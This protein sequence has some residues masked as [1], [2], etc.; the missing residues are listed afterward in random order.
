MP[1]GAHLPSHKATKSA[2]PP[3]T[4]NPTKAAKGKRPATGNKP[5]GSMTVTVEMMKSGSVSVNVSAPDLNAEA[6]E[7]SQRDESRQRDDEQASQ[8]SDDP[9]AGSPSWRSLPGSGAPL[10][11]ISDNMVVLQERVIQ[12]EQRLEQQRQ[13]ARAA[14]E[15]LRTQVAALTAQLLQTQRLAPSPANTKA[16]DTAGRATDATGPTR[17]GDLTRLMT[18]ASLVLN[19]MELVRTD[20][21]GEIF[22]DEA[23]GDVD[24]DVEA[25]GAAPP[26]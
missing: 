8:R 3:K 15:Q 17:P 14:Q 11:P 20:P 9:A 18:E 4:S 19:R 13:Q 5:K 10:Q 2:S 1:G 26:P 12:L 6:E 7:S 21:R 23:F 24:A 25:A 16:V 22:S